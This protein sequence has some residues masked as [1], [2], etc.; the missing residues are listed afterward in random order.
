M[1]IAEKFDRIE[2]LKGKIDQLLPRKNWDDAF[3]RKVKLDFTY[4]SNK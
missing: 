3:F 4:N 2:T 1:N